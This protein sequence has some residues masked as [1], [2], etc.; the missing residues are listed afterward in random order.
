MQIKILFFIDSLTSGGKERRLTE[1]MKRLSRIDDISFSL[2]LMSDDIH[3]EEI[4][5]LNIPIH[6]AVRN[7]KRDFRVYQ[8]LFQICKNERPDIVHCWDGMTAVYIAPICKLLKIKFVN[9]MIVDT[10]VHFSVFHKPWWMAKLAFPISDRIVGNS[11]AG[12]LAYKAPTRKSLCIHNGMDLTR[13]ENLSQPALLKEEIIGSEWKNAFI[14]GMVAAFEER[15]DY[16]TLVAAALI[17]IKKHRDIYFVFVGDGYKLESIKQNIPISEQDKFRFLGKRS[18]VETIVNIFDIGVL[19]TNNK[20]HGEGI[21]NSILEY[22]AL[23]KPVIATIG[24]GT[25]EII[26]NNKNGFLID[27]SEPIQLVEKIE[28]LKNNPDLQQELGKYGQAIFREQFDIEIMTRKYVEL[29]HQ[30]LNKA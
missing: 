1:L 19:L 8:K 7:R 3:Y 26:E 30:L 28:M 14:I 2:V 15:K 29:Y 5:Q 6:F 12:L 18:K 27:A 4:K 9:G 21:S 16:E 25:S 20:V 11:N 17:L 22:M 10:P 13:F 24:G 23:G